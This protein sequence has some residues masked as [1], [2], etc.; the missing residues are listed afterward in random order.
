M[1]EKRM[2]KFLPGYETFLPMCGEWIDVNEG[3]HY[4]IYPYRFR[5]DIFPW[6]TDD[7]KAIHHLLLFIEIGLRL[8]TKEVIEENKNFVNL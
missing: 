3:L 8:N 4:M 6:T 1:K 5:N 7:F 2:L